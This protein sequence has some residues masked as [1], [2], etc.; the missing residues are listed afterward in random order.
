MMF[1]NFNSTGA[2]GTPLVSALGPRGALHLWR[3]VLPLSMPTNFTTVAGQP[4]RT[5]IDHALLRGP[6]L[7]ASH[8]VIPTPS[9]HVGLHVTFTL[10]ESRIDPYAWRLWRWRS[11]TVAEFGQFRTALSVV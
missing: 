3:L 8:E 4:R 2:P 11:A 6:I 5:S 9:S 7:E 10:S 1:A